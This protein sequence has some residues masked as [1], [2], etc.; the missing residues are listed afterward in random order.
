MTAAKCRK[1][2]RPVFTNGTQPERVTDINNPRRK[3]PCP[4]HQDNRCPPK[5]KKRNVKGEPIKWSPDQETDSLA[6]LD[7]LW[8]VA[9]HHEERIDQPGP[10][11]G[12]PRLH[13]VFEAFLFEAAMPIF[14]GYRAVERKFQDLQNWNRL[15]LSIK[16]AYPNHPNRRLSL[17]P[18]TRRQYFYFR[19]HHMSEEDLGTVHR[20]ATEGCLEASLEMGMLDPTKGSL[21]H[22]DPTQ[23]LLGDGTRIK[24]R[25]KHGAEGSYDEDG[26]QTRRYDRDSVQYHAKEYKYKGTA[27]GQNLVLLIGRNPYRNER[28][29]IDA[30]FVTDQP[31]GTTFANMILD[32]INSHPEVTKGL[33]GVTYDMG[34]HP[35][36]ID[37]L[38]DAGLI[39]IVKVPRAKGTKPKSIALGPHDFTHP[40]TGQ[41]FTLTV[42]AVD[43][44]PCITLF[45]TDNHDYYQP[46][47][48]IQTKRNRN[49]NTY[50]FYGIWYIPHTRIVNPALAGATTTI[51]HSSTTAEKKATPHRRR[52]TAL[53]QTP[54]TD[55]DFD[56][57]SGLRQDSESGNSEIKY[58]LP[59]DRARTVGLHRQRINMIFYRL[60]R[61]NKALTAYHNRT[62]QDPT[63][64][65][66]QQ[67]PIRAGPTQKA[68]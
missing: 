68:A 9:E 35:K 49:K 57:L 23:I 65:Y 52:S 55:P 13:T 48:R 62:N 25:F 2:R 51:R 53:R 14:G 3:L 6:C 31:E 54:E 26:N 50:T 39:T 56:R 11:V 36:D 28:V 7:L 67:H 24:D 15:R 45:H 37:R 61:L 38:M 16:Q 44:T 41:T 1:G 27:F 63:R 32:L 42:T 8:K 59:N 60:Y 47:E 43:G 20:S 66:G 5:P 64:W 33:R 18:I 21:T 58:L 34:L 19:E 12:R 46:L 22:P 29:I 4:E 40:L 30:D 10:R 17:R